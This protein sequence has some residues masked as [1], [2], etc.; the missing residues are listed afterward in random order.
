ML[1]VLLTSIVLLR[2]LAAWVLGQV[3]EIQGQVLRTS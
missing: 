2:F 1:D 3:P